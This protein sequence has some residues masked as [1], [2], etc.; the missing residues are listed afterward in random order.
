[1]KKLLP[2]QIRDVFQGLELWLSYRENRR[3]NNI[4]RTTIGFIHNIYLSSV[5]GHIELGHNDQRN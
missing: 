4:C 1:M 5:S 2:D 3:R